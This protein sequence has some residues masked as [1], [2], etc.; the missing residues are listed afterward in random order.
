VSCRLRKWAFEKLQ[1]IVEV[2]PEFSLFNFDPV[3]ELSSSAM[4]LPSP[5][6][7]FKVV[8]EVE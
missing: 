5:N 3:H 7:G 1:K 2:P 8:I 4:E 6:F